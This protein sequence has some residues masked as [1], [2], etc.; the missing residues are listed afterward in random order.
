[1]CRVDDAE[2]ATLWYSRER[3]ASKDWKC[4]ECYR[5]IAGGERYREFNSLFDGRWSRDRTCLHCYAAGDWL[6][7]TCGGYLGTELHEELI[8]HWDEGYRSIPFA[9]LIVGMRTKWHDGRDPIPTG[10]RELATTMMH[11]RV[12]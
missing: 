9:R 2:P 8:E 7:A 3:T 4:C 12:A 10:M 11:R 5:R 1:M 6:M